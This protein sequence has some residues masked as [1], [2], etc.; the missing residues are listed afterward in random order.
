[1]NRNPQFG[2]NPKAEAVRMAENAGL[3]N[4]IT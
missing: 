3:K 1:M 2:K 4:V